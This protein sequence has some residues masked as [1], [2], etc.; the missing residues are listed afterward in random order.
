MANA[1]TVIGETSKL[2]DGSGENS[3]PILANSQAIR[4]MGADSNAIPTRS[5]ATRNRG[6]NSM[7]ITTHSQVTKNRGENTSMKQVIRRSERIKQC[8]DK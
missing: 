7:P 4:N 5:Q 2:R 6:A 3:K 1:L 8:M